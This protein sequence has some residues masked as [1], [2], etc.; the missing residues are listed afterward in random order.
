M[1]RRVLS[2]IGNFQVCFFSRFWI[3]I[4]DLLGKE[5]CRL[6]QNVTPKMSSLRKGLLIMDKSFLIGL[7][8]FIVSIWR[9]LK[10]W[11]KKI[12]LKQENN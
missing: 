7:I 4:R 11:K 1:I 2:R 9:E 10:G 5:D 8:L 6:L 3:R 12:I